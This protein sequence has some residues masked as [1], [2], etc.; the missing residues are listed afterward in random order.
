MAN[1]DA[2]RMTAPDCTAY[3][4]ER[5]GSKKGEDEIIPETS[6]HQVGV[7]ILV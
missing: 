3:S 7:H 1:N 5:E 6:H 4:A 2:M